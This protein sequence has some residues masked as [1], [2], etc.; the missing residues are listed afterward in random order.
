MLRFFL[1]S[2]EE[3]FSHLIPGN[4]D[5]EVKLENVVANG[6]KM[7]RFNLNFNVET[8]GNENISF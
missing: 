1:P 4:N 6:K 7:N 3:N 5:V 2:L 8:A